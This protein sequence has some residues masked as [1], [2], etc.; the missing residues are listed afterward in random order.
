MNN[1]LT[2]GWSESSLREWEVDVGPTAGLLGGV[3][4]RALG[5]VC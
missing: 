2:S 4:A 1:G 3:L 5:G